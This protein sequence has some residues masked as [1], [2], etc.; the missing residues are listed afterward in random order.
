MD[1][2]VRNESV[3]RAKAGDKIKITGTPIVVPDIAQLIGNKINYHRDSTQGRALDG[4]G[5]DGVTGLKA[6]G[7]RQLAYK[8]VFLASFILQV[9]QKN[10]LS[11]LHDMEDD[12]P[13]RIWIS[14]LTP[15]QRQMIDDMRA[16]KRIYQKLAASIA[17]H[18]Y[19]SFY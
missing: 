19:G 15:S 14:Q 7:V 16:D 17:P 1:I 13:H 4:L 18:I 3:E 8:T 12:D 6:L 11:A 5:Q 9:D 2:I 10:A